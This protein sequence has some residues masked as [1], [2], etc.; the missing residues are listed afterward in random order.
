MKK[1]LIAIIVLVLVGGVAFFYLTRPVAAPSPDDSL[2]TDEFSDLDE[3][4]GART[5]QISPIG[6][7]VE[8]NVGE[9]LRGNS[10]VA[11]GTTSNV[12]GDFRL[13]TENN[14]RSLEL[15]EI[16]INAR[17]FKT[18][19]D[20]RDTMIA[21]F[22][23]RSE[24]A[25]NEFIV[26][27]PK[28]IVGLPDSLALGTE[29]EFR[30]LGDLTIAGVTKSTFF[31]VVATF[32]EEEIIGTAETMIKRSDFSINIPKVPSVA[33]VEDEVT[34]KASIVAEKIAN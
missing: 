14:V 2:P 22:I 8:F 23:L 27:S 16:K 12:I 24:E 10:V 28:D 4:V 6:S 15:G 21:R 31:D 32:G 9:V 30:I 26:F 13:I 33:S 19:S 17:T 29:Y 34:L 18:D 5:Y 7:E 3:G 25:A 20:N 1:I 11:I